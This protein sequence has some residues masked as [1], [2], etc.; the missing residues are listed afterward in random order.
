MQ[1]QLP[2]GITAVNLEGLS[3]G[4]YTLRAGENSLL[5]LVQ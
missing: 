4:M 5:L 3:K 1:K 2:A